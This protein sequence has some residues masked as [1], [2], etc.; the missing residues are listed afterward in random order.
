M[1]S[2]VRTHQEVAEGGMMVL[3]T[4]E[5]TYKYVRTES[6]WTSQSKT[7]QTQGD[8]HGQVQSQEIVGAGPKGHESVVTFAE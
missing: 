7:F 8:N 6:Q 1:S 3:Q 4:V 5:P 2:Q